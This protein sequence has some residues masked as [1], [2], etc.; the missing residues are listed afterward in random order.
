M[1]RRSYRVSFPP[2]IFGPYGELLPVSFDGGSNQLGC[3]FTNMGPEASALVMRVQKKLRTIEPAN[4]RD[5]RDPERFSRAP[6]NC[7]P[8]GRPPT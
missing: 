7:R 4:G 5:N 3:P 2:L 8:C 6:S 1:T